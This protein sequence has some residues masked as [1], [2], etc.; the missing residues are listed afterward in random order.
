MKITSPA[1]EN[2]QTIP[3]K[4]TCIDGDIN[5]PLSFSDVPQNAKSL[6]LIV[7]DPDAPGGTWTHWVVFNISPNVGGIGENSEPDGIEAMTSF[8]KPGYG[9][10][11]PPPASPEQLQRGE[12]GTHRYFFKLYALDL[13]LDLTESADK[14][15]VEEAMNGHILAQAELVGLFSK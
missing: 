12:S 9:G 4:Y 2:Q 15:A 10:P 3:A 14:K 5:P 1:F 8:G 6:V 13:M 7:D 11:C